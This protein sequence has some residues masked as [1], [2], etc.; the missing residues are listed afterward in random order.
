MHPYV[1]QKKKT[2]WLNKR[3]TRHSRKNV[4]HTFGSACRIENMTWINA[5]NMMVWLRVD[6]GHNSYMPMM[7]AHDKSIQ[8]V[9][10]AHLFIQ[11]QATIFI[12]IDVLS[13]CYVHFSHKKKLFTYNMFSCA[14]FEH[15]MLGNR[16][17][18][19]IQQGLVSFI[20]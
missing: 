10:R 5:S 8:P 9:M 1:V 13:V 3:L 17:K 12:C 4:H 18:E 20:F 14:W 6:W 2:Y 16:A 19:E 7:L 11:W 15:I